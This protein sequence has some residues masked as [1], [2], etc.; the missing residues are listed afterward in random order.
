[1]TH[2]NEGHP[3]GAS[4][5]AEQAALARARAGFSPTPADAARVR[6]RLAATLTGGAPTSPAHASASYNTTGVARGWSWARRL[7]AGASIAAAAGAGGYGLGHRAGLR[8]G[9]GQPAAVETRS[10]PA[11]VVA[12]ESGSAC[13][14]T[15]DGWPRRCP[16]GRRSPHPATRV[17][18]PQAPIGWRRRR[19]ARPSLEEEVRALRAVERALREGSPGLALALLGE[20]DRAVPGRASEEERAATA[21]IARCGLGQAPFGVDLAETF[22]EQHPSSVYVKR[23][24][25]ACGKPTAP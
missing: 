5:D 4:S 15:C 20:L 21:A 25:Q 13:G 12:P 22:D 23:V 3:M 14:R 18:D 24:R 2:L 11:T 6:Q 10:A 16:R 7:L 17:A 9:L 19:R 8:A 1:M